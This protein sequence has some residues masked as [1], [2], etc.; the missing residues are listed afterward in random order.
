MA[1]EITLEMKDD[2]FSVEEDETRCGADARASARRHPVVLIK[3][4]R[5][6][7]SMETSISS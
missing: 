2:L 6:I 5:E 1:S 7:I 3:H 4:N